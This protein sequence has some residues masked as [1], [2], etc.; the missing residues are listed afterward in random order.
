MPHQAEVLAVGCRGRERGTATVVTRGEERME[1]LFP[2]QEGPVA[3]TLV[4]WGVQGP[5]GKDPSYVQSQ[6]P[7]VPQYP[8]RIQASL[9]FVVPL[10]G[11]TASK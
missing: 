1:A 2:G 11:R 7:K 9:L 10:S 3:E 5:S 8:V 4:Y 6:V